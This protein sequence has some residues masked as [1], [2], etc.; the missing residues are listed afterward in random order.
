MYIEQQV[1]AC[2]RPEKQYPLLPLGNKAKKNENYNRNWL[3]TIDDIAICDVGHFLKSYSNINNK[4]IAEY[5]SNSNYNP[6][7]CKC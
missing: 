5:A 2:K 3:L 1:M 6:C 4:T 7:T